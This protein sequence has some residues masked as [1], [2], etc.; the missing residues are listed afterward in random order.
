MRYKLIEFICLFTILSPQLLAAATPQT[1]VET[2][3]VVNVHVGKD[4]QQAE[5]F[6]YTAPNGWEITDVGLV[7]T[8][9][10][11]DAKY[12][13]ASR[14]NKEVKVGWSVHSE[15]VRGPFQTV[16]DTH[17]AF[18]GLNMNV[19]LQKQPDPVSQPEQWPKVVAVVSGIFFLVVIL[20][21]ALFIP[22]PSPFR[23][24][25]FRIILA[26]AAAGFGSALPGVLG[27]KIA[28]IP[29]TTI[30]AGGA[31]ALFV[32]IYIINPARLASSQPPS[33]RL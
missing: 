23:L 21:V 1:R 22:H 17:T 8:T 16:I 32:L 20:I 29:N 3:P 7:E 24:F 15:T 19:T 10:G 25:V 4:D 11:G 5:V 6:T 28:S 9:K 2:I 31:I 14:T 12:S 30:E 13:I 27:I 33:T 26:I 18:L